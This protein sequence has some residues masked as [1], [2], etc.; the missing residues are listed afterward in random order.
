MSFAVAVKISNIPANLKNKRSALIGIVFLEED[1]RD[2]ELRCQYIFITMLSAQNPYSALIA[3][4]RNN[5]PPCSTLR[6]H[7]DIFGSLVT[8]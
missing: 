1:D 3:N 4:D 7:P 6:D 2:L 5:R 8:N